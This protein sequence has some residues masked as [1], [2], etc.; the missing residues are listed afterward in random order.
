MLLVKKMQED[1]IVPTCSHPGEDFGYD[2]YSVED[3]TLIPNKVVMVDTGISAQ[4]YMPDGTNKV[5]GLLIKDRSSMAAKGITTSGGV[6]DASYTDN[7]RILMTL[8]GTCHNESYIIP[9]GAKIAQL[10]P[11]PVATNSITEVD[12]LPRSSR[13]TNGFGSTGA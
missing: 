2:V 1:A 10:I 8:H 3:V 11:I 12:E 5:W 9:K 13:G 4:Y 6:I 7:I